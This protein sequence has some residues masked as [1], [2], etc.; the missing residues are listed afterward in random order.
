M[1]ELFE[2]VGIGFLLQ[3]AIQIVKTW[4]DTGTYSVRFINRDLKYTILLSMS[5]LVVIL[6]FWSVQNI[7][8]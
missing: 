4:V 7:Y 5:V 1:V 2:I 3:F 8:G 6:T